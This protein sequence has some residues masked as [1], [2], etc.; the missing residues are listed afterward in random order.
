MGDSPSMRDRRRIEIPLSIDLPASGFAQKCLHSGC[1]SKLSNLQY[2]SA[3]T[4][5]IVGGRRHQRISSW[6][7]PSLHAKEVKTHRD[8]LKR[9]I[10]VQK[11]RL[12]RY[13]LLHFDST[14]DHKR[15]ARLSLSLLFPLSTTLIS[16]RTII[17]KVCYLYCPSYQ[18]LPTRRYSI[19]LC[20]IGRGCSKSH[21]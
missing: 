12:G 11:A 1:R 5:V 18:S 21:A 19:K 8:H 2:L 20:L 6:V 13:L 14:T 17:F 15:F 3:S 7:R 10:T 9:A 16:S 4:N